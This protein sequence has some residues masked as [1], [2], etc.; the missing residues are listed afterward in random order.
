MVVKM[1]MINNK[2]V[3][4]WEWISRDWS[5][6]LSHLCTSSNITLSNVENNRFIDHFCD[7]IRQ[8]AGIRFSKKMPTATTRRWIRCTRGSKQRCR[9]CRRVL[10]GQSILCCLKCNS[11]LVGIYIRNKIMEGRI[12]KY[13]ES[14]TR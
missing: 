6:R 14:L 2:I 11:P 10:T 9:N 13:R 7:D 1:K 4:S 8:S 3:V 12:N 5:D